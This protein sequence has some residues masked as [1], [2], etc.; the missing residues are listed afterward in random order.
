[1]YALREKVL[2]NSEKQQYSLLLSAVTRHLVTTER[3]LCPDRVIIVH[4]KHEH[5]CSQRHPYNH[6]YINFDECAVILTTL[7]RPVASWP[8]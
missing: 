8:H 1:M 5:T 7:C 2:N 4:P 3:S 6:T